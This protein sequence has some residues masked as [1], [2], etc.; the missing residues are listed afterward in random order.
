MSNTTMTAEDVNTSSY[1]KQIGK[2]IKEN[3]RR[4]E[5]LWTNWF[6]EHTI[7]SNGR[8]HKLITHPN[9]KGHKAFF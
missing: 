8:A 3:I 1:L 9:C 4:P 6:T 5:Q 7:P 2:N